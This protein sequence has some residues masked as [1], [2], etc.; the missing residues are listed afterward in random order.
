MD[1]VLELDREHGVP[2]V[3]ARF[4]CFPTAAGSSSIEYNSAPGFDDSEASTR[5][6]RPRHRGGLRQGVR[7]RTMRCRPRREG[8]AGRSGAARPR[9]CPCRHTD[10]GATRR[11][12][13]CRA[14]SRTSSRSAHGW[15]W[16]VRRL[17]Q[18][19]GTSVSAS[20]SRSTRSCEGSDLLARVDAP[21]PIF[22]AIRARSVR[23]LNGLRAGCCADTSTR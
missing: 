4:D 2:S 18:R 10:R 11:L 8:A 9:G 21:S 22:E 7:L 6:S 23:V 17:P 14:G 1:A 20:A 5:R 15:W 12:P 16:R 13:S 19:G 3:M